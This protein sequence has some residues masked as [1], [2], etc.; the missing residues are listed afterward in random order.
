[1]KRNLYKRKASNIEQFKKFAKEEWNE[2][3]KEICRNLIKSMPR[4][5]Q[6][7]IENDGVVTKY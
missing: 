4:R 1:M 5:L 6:K 3:P 7:V 2:I